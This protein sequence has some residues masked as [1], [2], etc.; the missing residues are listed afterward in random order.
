MDGKGDAGLGTGWMVRPL[1]E[2]RWEDC[3]AF[4]RLWWVRV[5]QV[6]TEVPEGLLAGRAHES[7]GH[8][9]AQLGRESS[10]R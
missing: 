4:G 7:R 3:Y 1:D 10:Q 6:P 2:M 9:S 8:K 5:R